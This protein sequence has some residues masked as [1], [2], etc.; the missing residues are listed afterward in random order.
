MSQ[1]LRWK[2]FGNYS[3]DARVSIAVS[4][5]AVIFAAETFINPA[6]AYEPFMSALAFAAAGVAGYRAFKTKAY[7]G[8]LALPLSLVWLNPLLGGEWFDTVS[9]IH[10]AAHSAYAMLFGLYAYTFMRMAV[11]KPSA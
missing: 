1:D 4:A 11:T 9:V 8:F 2:P 6:S 7:L 5:I 3:K 10:F